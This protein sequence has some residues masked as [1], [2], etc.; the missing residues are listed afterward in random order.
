MDG[1]WIYR[2]ENG[3]KK[4]EGEYVKDRREGKWV[5]WNDRGEVILEQNFHEGKPVK[6]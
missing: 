5:E 2:H 6:G 4:A 3:Q 1:H